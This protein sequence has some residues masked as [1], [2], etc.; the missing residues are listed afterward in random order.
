MIGVDL[1]L[2][3]FAE[4]VDAVR[5]VWHGH[6]RLRLHGQRTEGD[7]WTVGN[8]C[9]VA[10]RPG[11][12]K[13]LIGEIVAEHGGQ[14]VRGPCNT[15]RELVR[16]SFRRLGGLDAGVVCLGHGPPLTGTTASLLHDAITASTV[17]APRLSRRLTTGSP[18]VVFP[19]RAWVG[20][21]AG[22]RSVSQRLRR[23]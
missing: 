21:R 19:P 8:Y 18:C 7:L 1:A 6:C 2:H 14:V 11:H 22:Q 17:P 13:T 23:V 12:A 4:N 15:D 9:G 20:F 16:H 10:W 5:P 3:L